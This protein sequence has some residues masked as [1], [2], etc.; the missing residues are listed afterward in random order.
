MIQNSNKSVSAYDLFHSV[1]GK[2]GDWF[3]KCN[4]NNSVNIQIDEDDYTVKC[5]YKTRSNSALI[6]RIEDY[7]ECLLKDKRKGPKDN[8]LTIIATDIYQI[9]FKN[10][11]KSGNTHTG[12]QLTN[13][14]KWLEHIMWVSDPNNSLAISRAYNITIKIKKRKR[15][16]LSRNNSIL[17]EPPSPDNNCK[18]ILVTWNRNGNEALKLDFVIDRILCIYKDAYE[19]YPYIDK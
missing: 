6:F 7:K 1:Y 17:I 13:G 11:K 16:S 5:K 19:R 10:V 2:T 12:Q 18:Y 8:D 4:K 14:K 3:K 15:S 9:E